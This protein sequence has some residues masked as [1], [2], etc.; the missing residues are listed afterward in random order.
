[1]AIS[2]PRIIS[3]TKCSKA[4]GYLLNCPFLYSHYK[5]LLIR[6][7]PYHCSQHPVI[8]DTKVT[9]KEYRIVCDLLIW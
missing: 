2:N 9:R 7:D 4:S 8:Q 5:R 3:D 1:M 6:V